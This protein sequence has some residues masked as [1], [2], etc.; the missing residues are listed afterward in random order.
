MTASGG[1]IIA[2]KLYVGNLSFNTTEETLRAL[3]EADGRRVEDL[4]IITDR[5]TGR[6]RGF[7]FVQM[8]SVE[9]ARAAISALNGRLLDGYECRIDVLVDPTGRPIRA[10]LADGN[11]LEEAERRTLRAVGESV[12]RAAANLDYTLNSL[13]RMLSRL[14]GV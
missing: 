7:A 1:W 5:H 3:F 4:R 13:R 12:N 6:S 2:T 8:G 14:E 9:D 10:P 11:A